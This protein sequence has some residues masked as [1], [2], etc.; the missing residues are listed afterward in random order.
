MRWRG[1]QYLLYWRSTT[2][3]HLMILSKEFKTQDGGFISQRGSPTSK[4][5]QFGQQHMPK[6]AQNT[7]LSAV[8]GNPTAV[9]HIGHRQ[10]K[11]HGMILHKLFRI[12]DNVLRPKSYSPTSKVW[13]KLAKKHQQQPRKPVLVEDLLN[14]CYI[15]NQPLSSHKMIISN[16]FGVKMVS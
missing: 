13:P 2:P 4:A 14:I 10:F 3:F 9:I 1:T 12:H 15:G 11:F 8:A 7:S 6:I 5:T 16:I